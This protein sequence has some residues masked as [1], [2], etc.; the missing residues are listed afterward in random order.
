MD[1]QRLAEFLSVFNEVAREGSFS[2]AA[3]RR[4]VTPSSVIRQIDALEASLGATLFIRSTR[5][6]VL[7]DIGQALLVRARRILGELEDARREITDMQD[8]VAGSLRIA[9][10]PA[11]GRYYVLPV[12]SRLLARYSRLRIELDLTERPIDPVD[13]RLDAAICIGEPGEGGPAA[14]RIAVET[15]MLC[16]SPSYLARHSAPS[17]PEELAEHCL[18]D[19]M[20]GV[21]L[22]GW[23]S[24]LGAPLAERPVLSVF[25]CDDIDT[26]RAAA[27]AGVGI[28]YLPDWAVGADI[29]GGR[30]VRLMPEYSGQFSRRRGIYLLRAPL[31]PSGPLRVFTD[32]LRRSIGNPPSWTQ[33]NA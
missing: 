6:L 21:D 5:S 31:P 8:D 1:N 22:L 18:L 26:L 23:A 15:R 2:G 20:H 29:A 32:A 14:A 28:G 11:F 13:G 30:L 4:G 3:R 19:R 25:S 33:V 10:V 17:S 16:A 12:V 27:V 9:S 24:I 7:T